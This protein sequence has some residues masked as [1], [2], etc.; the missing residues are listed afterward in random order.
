MIPELMF[1]S[2]LITCLLDTVLVVQGDILSSSL[3]L[4]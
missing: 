1:F 2:I 4:E 3:N